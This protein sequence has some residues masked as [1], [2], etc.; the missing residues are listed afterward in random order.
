MRRAL[1]IVHFDKDHKA[2]YLEL[3]FDS[4]AINDKGYADDGSLLISIS[5]GEQRI[6]F[7]LSVSEAALLKE[8]LDYILALLAKQYIEIDEKAAKERQ[9]K[10]VKKDQKKEEYLDEEVEEEEG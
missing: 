3:S 4:A 1:R 8:R 6:A 9:Q 10:Q 7:Q 2:K 5:Q